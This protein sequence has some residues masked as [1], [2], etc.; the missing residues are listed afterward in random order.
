MAKMRELRLLCAGESSAHT[1]ARLAP[2]QLLPLLPCQR[3]RHT[4]LC[5]VLGCSFFRSPASPSASNLSVD[6]ANVR[7]SRANLVFRSSANWTLDACATKM[8]KLLT[9]A[10]C[11]QQISVWPVSGKRDA[12][13]KYAKKRRKG[14]QRR[15]KKS[16]MRPER[17]NGGQKP[18]C[19]AKKRRA[20]TEG[21]ARRGGAVEASVRLVCRP[22]SLIAF[23]PRQPT[24][25]IAA[26][27]LFVSTQS[28]RMC[29][30]RCCVVAGDSF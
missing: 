22:G 6:T 30:N 21:V 7:C 17:E 11:K 10:H 14:R 25:T 19:I 20:W 26:W 8:K 4:C 28:L 16:Q 24:L 12:L 29:C 18:V 2:I 1:D 9:P 5:N 23:G 3:I 13:V 15:R 27:L